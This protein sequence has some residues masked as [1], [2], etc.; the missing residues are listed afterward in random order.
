METDRKPAQ[1]KEGSRG[2]GKPV[3]ALRDGFHLRL[4][5]PLAA[6]R[7]GLEIA[8]PASRKVR[9]LLGYLALAP[10]PVLRAHLCELLWDVANDPRSELRWCLTK[11]RPVIDDAR[12]PRLVSDGQWVSI[13][14]SDLEVDAIAFSRSIEKAIADGSVAD[15]KHLVRTI[16]GDFLEGLAVDRS[17]MFDNWLR[18]QRHRFTSWHS[19]ALAR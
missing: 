7:R 4:L 15:L 8:M 14:V 17:P 16:Q 2:I 13:D 11:L 19:R 6:T 9:A 3:K 10:R 12:W 18:G 1:S 5:G